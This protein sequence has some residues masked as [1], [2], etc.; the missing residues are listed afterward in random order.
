VDEDRFW[1]LIEAAW[2]PV[3]EAGDFRHRL[4]GRT[5]TWQEASAV[6]VPLRA[7]AQALKQ[8][9]DRLPAE[10]LLAFERILERKLYDLDTQKLHRRIGGSDDGFLYARGFVV[11]C[12]RD[13]YDAVNAN[14]ARAARWDLECE[15][16]CF[17]AERLYRE[18]YGE[19][20]DSGLSKG[21]GSNEAG[22][23][24]LHRG[25]RGPIEGGPSP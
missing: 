14:P 25:P 24:R 19:L 9:L 7:F 18:N 23:P 11:A 16:M 5:F 8:G 1:A 2:R 21:S 12:G 22:W 20:P 15:T 3:G 13:Y 6:R 10:E 17:L 4:A